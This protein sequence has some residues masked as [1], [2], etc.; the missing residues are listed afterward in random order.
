MNGG[1][2]SKDILSHDFSYIPSHDLT[3]M[4]NNDIPKAHSS[5]QYGPSSSHIDDRRF[6]HNKKNH[7]KLNEE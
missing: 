2:K 4:I 6:N 5:S 1:K 7:S 3:R